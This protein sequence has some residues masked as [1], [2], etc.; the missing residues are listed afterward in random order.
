MKLKLIS[1]GLLDHLVVNSP[2]NPQDRPT[3]VV[4]IK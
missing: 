3:V 1:M 2:H 4:D